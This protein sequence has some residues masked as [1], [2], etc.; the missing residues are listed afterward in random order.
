MKAPACLQH[1]ELWRELVFGGLA[2]QMQNKCLLS[3]PKMILGE[4]TKK[5]QQFTF[6][7]AGSPRGRSGL[8]IVWNPYRV[9]GDNDEDDG[10][11]NFVAPEALPSA[12]ILDT[13][14]GDLDADAV[15]FSTD[16]T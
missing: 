2:T 3:R 12:D 15:L 8:R 7:T 10:E 13:I 11:S 6:C 9:P 16:G 1:F 4:R 14:Y 5:T